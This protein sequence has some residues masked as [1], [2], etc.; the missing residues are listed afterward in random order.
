MK[1]TVAAI[2]MTALTL[3]S[4]VFLAV[5]TWI[6]VR[7]QRLI[8]TRIHNENVQCLLLRLDN[9]AVNAVKE[10]EQS[11]VSNLK[12]G[13]PADFVKARDMALASI[14]THLG[15]QGLMNLQKYLGLD[16]AAAVEKLITS[17]LEARVHDIKA[18]NSIPAGAL[19][20]QSANTVNPE[21]GV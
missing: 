6:G 20:G 10:V 12:D 16:D 2:G 5:V 21:K 15:T 19:T 8:Q 1:D 3:L 7:L 9:A 17:A 4:P 18:Q 13:T 11:F 14:R